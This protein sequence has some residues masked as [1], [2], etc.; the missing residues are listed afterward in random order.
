MKSFIHC[1]AVSAMKSCSS[2]GKYFP[3]RVVY[4]IYLYIDSIWRF[5][6]Y[7]EVA[8][9]EKLYNYTLNV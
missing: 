1:I 3:M 8:E 9:T 2:S 6:W 4:S 5:N 7:I